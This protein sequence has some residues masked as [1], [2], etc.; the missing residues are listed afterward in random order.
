MTTEV[1]GRAA[2]RWWRSVWQ[3]G[4]GR[5]QP[6]EEA[7]VRQREMKEARCPGDT[8][9]LEATQRHP[10]EGATKQ[11]RACRVP[12]TEPD[13]RN[14]ADRHKHDRIANNRAPCLQV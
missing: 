5:H 2:C 10:E 11:R 7:Q 14:E 3:N 13:P 8:C 6:E 1:L 12:G 4:G 9:G